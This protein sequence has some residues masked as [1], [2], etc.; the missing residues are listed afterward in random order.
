MA[1]SLRHYDWPGALR[2]GHKMGDLAQ[3]SGDTRQ[4]FDH[5]S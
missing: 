4:F 1:R 3:R 5:Q 2:G